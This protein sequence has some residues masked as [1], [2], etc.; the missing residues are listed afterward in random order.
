MN[1]LL[2]GHSGARKHLSAI[3]AELRGKPGI[4]AS[5]YFDGDFNYGKS[6]LRSASFILLGLSRTSRDVSSGEHSKEELMLGRIAAM[7]GRPACGLLQDEDGHI[8]A[9]YLAQY[10][11]VFTHV[12][13][14]DPKIRSLGIFNGDCNV[15]GPELPSVAET[16]L[17][18]PSR[19]QSLAD[20]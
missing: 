4:V 5:A 19:S 6:A 14:A 15:A 8:S 12:F 13:S 3:L 1:I 7:H 2:L 9:Q 11:H 10:G 17:S 18:I 20:A 16:I